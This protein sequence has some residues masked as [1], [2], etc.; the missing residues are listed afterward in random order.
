[1]YTKEE[2]YNLALSALLL[3]RQITNTATDK[4]NEAK[5]LNTNYDAAFR[6]ALADMDLDST[7]TL[8]TLELLETDPIDAWDYA[9]K[10]PTDCSFFRRILN[11][12]Y[13]ETTM[14][15]CT[16]RVPLRVAIH[17]G[18]KVIFSNEITATGEFITH[19]VPLSSLSPEA[20]LAV[21]YR[22]A[23]LAAPLIV[24]KGAS[25]LRTEL[26]QKYTILKSEA[27]ETDRKENFNFTDP[28]TESEFVEARLS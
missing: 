27:Q 25:R 7:A 14:D 2:I 15:N 22:L 6:S 19:E 16:T 17:G 8:E 1:M 9:Y 26:L 12:N 11:A 4:S 13:L 23:I 20:G 3:Q 10:Y 5:V 21:A 28:L 18:V 24:G